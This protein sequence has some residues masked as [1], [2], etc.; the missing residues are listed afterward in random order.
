M[1]V[2]E[3]AL[4][5][6]RVLAILRYPDGGDVRGT[7]RALH[8]GGLELAEVTLGTPGALEAV[9]HANA[10]GLVVGVGTVTTAAEVMDCVAAG[11][12]F[13][14]SPA[15]IPEVVDASLSAGLDVMPGVFTATEVV[16]A[17]RLGARTLKLFPGG[18]LGPAYLR[19]LLGPFPHVSFIP[20]G[21]ITVANS[22]AFLDAGA[23]A[24]A[25]GAD[26]VGRLAP[27]TAEEREVL[28][29]RVRRLLATVRPFVDVP[30]EA[31]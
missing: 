3:E 13:I 12:R 24:V 10:S 22:R 27:R 11:A 19:A 9:A 31:D 23:A 2:I 5:R 1:T 21:A 7:L 14:V 4:R 18:V 29:E 30:V 15:L 28:S 6:Q 26:L 17:L 16:E 8:A 20:T 25:L